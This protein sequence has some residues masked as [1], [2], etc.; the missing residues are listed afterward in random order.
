VQRVRKKGGFTGSREVE[1]NLKP[2]ARLTSTF[3]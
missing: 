3:L 1:V 2:T